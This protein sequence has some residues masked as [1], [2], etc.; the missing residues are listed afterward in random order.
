MTPAARI[1]AAIGVLDQVL[2]GAPAEQALLRWSRA[3]RFAGSG[4]RAAV[5]DL[6]FD[7]L[8]RRDTLAALGGGPGG[9][10]LMIGLCRETG[11][12]LAA[13]FTGEGHAPVPLT[14]A[15]RAGHA[16]P[17]DNLPDWLRPQWRRALGTD[18]DAV[19]AAMGQRAPV[20]LRHNPQRAGLAQALT[21]L[22][23]DGI[24]TV[25]DP[26]LTSALRVI[27][28]ARRVASG[29]AYGEGMVELQDLSPQLACA[30]LPCAPGMRVLDY[31]AGGGGK[32]LALAARNP[33]LRIEAHDAE[34][35]RMR[36]LPVRARRA[37]AAITLTARPSGH[38]GLV[39]AD[40]PCSG[41]GTWRRQPDAKWRLT[42][43]RLEQLRR[44]QASILD[45]AAGLVAAKGHLAYMT[46]SL[47]TAENDAQIQAFLQRNQ[48]FAL[49]QERLW[50]PL[51]ASDG[52][53]LA[54]LRRA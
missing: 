52:F 47:L 30:E 51:T 43:E 28:G 53:F 7:A 8:R 9:R 3:S 35:D 40:V 17:G 54:L 13:I 38:Y 44:I 27:S 32:A 15:E 10:G 50:T 37:G 21:A 42:P 26:R 20:W 23:A 34:P 11:E 1:S 49:V 2:Q 39:V 29:R 33:E 41:S 14:E 19:A 6:V 36:D 4:D 5:R 24:E 45:R 18:A 12:D 46:C 16:V 48:G 31:C 25:P 22:A